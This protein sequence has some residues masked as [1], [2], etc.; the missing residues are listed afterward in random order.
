ML[1][2]LISSY[3]KKT[4]SLTLILVRGIDPFIYSSLEKDDR[5]SYTTIWIVDISSSRPTLENRI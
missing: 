3:N 1:F 2:N 4:V 5:S